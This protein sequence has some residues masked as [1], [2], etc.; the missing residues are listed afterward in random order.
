MSNA[1]GVAFLSFGLLATGGVSVY[2]SPYDVRVGIDNGNGEIGTLTSPAES[3]VRAGVEYGGD[4][5]QYTGTLYIPGQGG[6]SWTEDALELWYA[7]V[8]EFGDTAKY[9]TTT[10]DVVKNPVRSMFK[11]TGT[12]Y[13]KQADTTIDM[14]RTVAQTTGLYL[15][16]QETPI[17]PR[18]VVYVDGNSYEVLNMENDDTAQP[19]VRFLCKQLQ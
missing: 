11:M 17:T 9:Q 10:F 16:T 4:G 12:G 2:A 3:D 5:D 8:E 6:T 7:L 13:G 15:L 19:S 1:Q 18:P 14:L